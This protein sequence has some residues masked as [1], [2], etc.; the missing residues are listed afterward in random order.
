MLVYGDAEDEELPAEL[1]SSVA[2]KTG[3]CLRMPAGHA[4]HEMLIRAFILAG[5]LVQGLAD[6]EFKQKGADDLSP[7]QEAGARLLKAFAG[8]IDCSWKSGFRGMLV[9]P[10]DWPDLL[11]RLDMEDR[12]RTRRGEG[13]AF[14]ALYPECYLAA[15]RA[16]GLGPE[17]VVLGLRS[18]GTGLAALVAAG[19]DAA[20][21]FSLRPVGHPFDRRIAATP[22]LTR[23]ILDNKNARYAI[24]DE[25]PG[26]SGSSFGCVADWLEGHGLAEQRIHVFPSHKGDPGPQASDRHRRR[27]ARLPRHCVEAD[28]LI[29]AGNE[30]E[31]QL[32]NWISGLVDQEIDSWRDVSGGAWRDLGQPNR[33]DRPPADMRNEK[34]KFLASAGDRSWL[35]KFAGL[36]EDGAW[37]A[38]K[39]AILGEAGFT[40]RI[41]GMRHGFLAERWIAGTRVS[42]VPIDRSEL[43][44]TAGR[45]LG[46][47]ARRLQ[48][49]RRGASLEDLRRMA[50]INA[51]ELLGP[52]A[53]CRI[54]ERIGDAGRLASNLGSVDTDNRLHAWEWIV[55]P[56]GKIL[57]TDALDHSA[58]HDLIGCQ[59]IAWDIAGAAVEF[60]LSADE[61]EELRHRVAA[62]AGYATGNEVVALFELFYLCFQAGLWTYA[63]ASQTGEEAMRATA[64]VQRYADCL[65]CLL[66]EE[67]SWLPRERGAL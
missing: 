11:G 32:R 38:R 17:T 22:E 34:R 58:A 21:A 3:A 39:A 13:Y 54:G 60:G 46:F 29:F 48:P 40:P 41:A 33:G 35:V 53:A 19:L 2:E 55:S 37:K 25:G 16:S 56:D 31:H 1:R 42:D 57:K 7:V 50:L 65:S 36:G 15:A 67:P 49:R 45:Y 24:V 8:A 30:A 14:Y 28:D 66:E 27:W 62:A 47:R 23:K 51:E 6:R 20:P 9:L 43:I 10:S 63:S 18:I 44:D 52:A 12:I 26:L 64:L 59:D 5:E 61:R 4:R